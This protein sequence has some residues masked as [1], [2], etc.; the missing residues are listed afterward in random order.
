VAYLSDDLAGQSQYDIMRKIGWSWYQCA[1][2]EAS[3]ITEKLLLR[4][5]IWSKK[6][7]LDFLEIS[8]RYGES[9]FLKEYDKVECMIQSDEE[10]WFSAIPLF[11]QALSSDGH[12][13]NGHEIF[14]KILSKLDNIPKGS[15]EERWK[16]I[17][18]IQWMN[19][20]HESVDSIFQRIL[21]ASFGKDTNIL[22]MLD[23]HFYLRLNKHLD[24]VNLIMDILFIVF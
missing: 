3:N 1:Y 16:F 7:G 2:Q 4:S 19:T 13:K 21:C 9:N 6:A 17:S 15:L 12:N 18:A 22:H 20:I 10:L 11:I 14:A 8:L 24:S 23:K 5:S